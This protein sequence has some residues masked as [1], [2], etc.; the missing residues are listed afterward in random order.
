MN[1]IKSLLLFAV[2]LFSCLGQ[3]RTIAVLAYGSLI[4][5]LSRGGHTLEVKNIFQP[6]PFILPISMRRHSSQGSDNE[7]ITAVIDNSQGQAKAIY[8]ATMNASD[9][10]LARE[11]LSM[12]EGS[13]GKLTYINYIKKDKPSLATESLIPNTTQWYTR[14]PQGEGP[15]IKDAEI[16]N[17]DAKKIADWAASNG[18]DAVIWA[19]YPPNLA[20]EKEAADKLVKAKAESNLFKNTVAYINQFPKKAETKF[21]KAVIGGIDALKKEYNISFP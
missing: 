16:S 8:F 15:Y 21:E 17:E 7:R 2:F 9:L 18:Y 19:S 6:A 14:K 20:N 5:E 11:N 1:L 12:R 10:K 13:N 3:A 4:N